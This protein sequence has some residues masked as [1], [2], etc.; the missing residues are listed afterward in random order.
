M[1][2]LL[3]TVADVARMLGRSRW[4]VDQLIA[5]GL[6]QTRSRP[7][8]SRRYVTRASL[9]AWLADGQPPPEPPARLYEIP[10][11][12]KVRGRGPAA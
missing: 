12:V 3:L 8:N 9:D 4:Y 11:V 10:G 6:L 5:D 2:E 7:N 1:T